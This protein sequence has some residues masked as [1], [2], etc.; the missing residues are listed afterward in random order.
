MARPRVALAS[1]PVPES[2]TQF[3]EKSLKLVR[4]LV[5]EAVD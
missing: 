5:T 2:P 1:R 3:T 4:G